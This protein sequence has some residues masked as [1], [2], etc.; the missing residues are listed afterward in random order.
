MD[1]IPDELLPNTEFDRG[2]FIKCRRYFTQIQ[3]FI[4]NT[5]A[6]TAGDIDI[7]LQHLCS[8][9]LVLNGQSEKETFIDNG[10]R[11][12]YLGNDPHSIRGCKTDDYEFDD[13]KTEIMKFLSTIILEL[14]TKASAHNPDL[15]HVKKQI[16]VYFNSLLHTITLFCHF[17]GSKELGSIN[18]FFGDVVSGLNGIFFPHEIIS[19]HCTKPTDYECGR[20]ITSTEAADGIKQIV[21][22]DSSV[23][24]TFVFV[25]KVGKKTKSRSKSKSGSK[26]KTKSRSKSK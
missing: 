6:V 2:E 3:R 10:S 12:F 5:T 16:N 7:A 21:L 1:S 4:H 25:A 22:V 23:S 15:V 14:F 11:C 19:I 18:T 24:N 26:S 8:F 20:A 13:K 17:I 9:M